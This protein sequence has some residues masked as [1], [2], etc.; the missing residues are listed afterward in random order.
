M[1]KILKKD[2]QY[3]ILLKKIHAITQPAKGILKFYHTLNIP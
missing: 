2:P 1:I 3:Q